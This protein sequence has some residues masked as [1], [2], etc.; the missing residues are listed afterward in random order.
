[1]AEK[2]ATRIGQR[3]TSDYSHLDGWTEFRIVNDTEL[4]QLM[5]ITAEAAEYKIVWKNPVPHIKKYHLEQLRLD[6]Q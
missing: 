6:L 2:T 5:A 3:L 1:M 4:A